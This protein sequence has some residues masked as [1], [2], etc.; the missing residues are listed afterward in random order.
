M[1]RFL[2]IGALAAAAWSVGAGYALGKV[3]EEKAAQLDAE[4]TPLGAIRAGNAAG[5]IP[6]WQGGIETPPPGYRPGD[7]HPNPFADDA[8]LFTITAANVDQYADRLSPGQLALFERYPET[9]RMPVYPTRRSASYPERIYRSART[10]ALSAELSPGG[11]GVTGSTGAFPFPIPENGLEAIWNHLLRYRGQQLHRTIAQVTPTASGVYNEV[12]IDERALYL[13]VQNGATTG[14]GD[15]QLALFLQ[16]VMA[17]ARLA[18][19]ILLV[20]E[21]LNQRAEDREAWT[22]NPGQRRVR[23][24]PNVA[25][26]NPGTASDGLRTSDQL[27]TFNGAP[28]RYRWQLKGRRELFIPYNNYRLHSDQIEHDQ[29]IAPGHIDPDFARYELHRVWE[30]EA[31]LK[32]GTSHIYARRTFFIDEDSWQIVVADH[33]DGRGELWRVSETY[34]INYYDV[35]L[36]WETLLAIYDLQNGRYLA[37]GLNN[38]LPVD[39]F[40]VALDERDFT[41][42]AIRRL[43]RR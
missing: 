42:S 12:R 7:H 39:D 10:N 14:S 33:Y 13:Y 23:R 34:T 9:W 11:N 25:Y 16:E 5:T 29:V 30:V 43:G 18:G 4:L 37:L 3:S 28:D 41:P 35:P 6:P 2:V 36:V 31:T 17:P 38:E 1:T 21:T 24:A 20:H 40:G 26:D 32:D 19:T 27:D 22:Y 8:V 15:N